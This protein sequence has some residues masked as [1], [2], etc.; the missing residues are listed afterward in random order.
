MPAQVL[1]GGLRAVGVRLGEDEDTAG[2]PDGEWRAAGPDATARSKSKKA[3]SNQKENLAVYA[4]DLELDAALLS[5]RKFQKAASSASNHSEPASTATGTGRS[6]LQLQLA[7][8]AVLAKPGPLDPID[9]P[10]AGGVA[11]PVLC[12]ARCFKTAGARGGS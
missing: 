11:L 6:L 7:T 2:K 1:A 8:A 9:D 4:H 12:V 3:R 10:W 5:V